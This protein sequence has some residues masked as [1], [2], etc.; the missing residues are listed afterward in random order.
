MQQLYFNTPLLQKFHL[1]I[2]QQYRK[3]KIARLLNSA[4][5]ILISKILHDS[6]INNIITNANYQ[7][8]SLDGVNPILVITNNVLDA[9]RLYLEL[10]TFINED[11]IAIFPNNEKL[12]YENITPQHYITANR[13]RVLWQISTKQ[14]AVVI[15]DAASLQERL[16]PVSYLYERMLILQTT[17][18]LNIMEL[19]RQLI[20]GN[21]SYVEQILES[22][23]FTIRGS[24]IDIIPMGHHELIRIELFDDEIESLKI[25]DQVTKKTIEVIDKIELI[26]VKEYPLDGLDFFKTKFNDYFAKDDTYNNYLNSVKNLSWQHLKAGTESYL[27]LFFENTYTIFDYLTNNWQIIYHDNLL[28]LLNNNWQ[29]ISRR[30]ALCKQQYPCLKPNDLFI[31][32]DNIF[33]KINAFNAYNIASNGD[34]NSNIQ[35]LPDI[36]IDQKAKQPLYRLHEFS[37]KYQNNWIILFVDNIGRVE[38]IKQML[39]KEGVAVNHIIDYTQIL[40]TAKLGVINLVCANLHNGF[41]LHDYIFITET[42]LNKNMPLINNNLNSIN[43]LASVRQRRK[44][45]LRKE[46]NVTKNFDHNAVLNNVADIKIGDLIVH[47]NHGIA[48][49]MGLEIQNICDV[50]Y[51][52][53]VLQYQNDAKIFV[54]INNL[55]LISKYSAIDNINNE[56]LVHHLGTNNWRKIIDKTKKNIDDIAAH[57][58]ELYAARNINSGIKFNLIEEYKTFAS[59]FG[60]EPTIDQVNCFN[61]VLTDM[62]SDKPMERLICGDVGFGKTEVAIRAAFVCAMNGYQVVVLC[63]T[64]LLV[65]Q[66]YQ[67]FINRFAKFPITIAEISRFKTKKEIQDSLILIKNGQIDIIIGTHRLIQNDVQFAKL[68]LILIDEEHRFGVAQK[69]KLKKLCSNVDT[70]SMTATPVPRSLSMALDGIRDL[71]II[72]TPPQKRLPIN[73]IICIEDFEIIK[74][75]ILRELRR[76]GQV[77]FLYNDVATIGS[78]YHKLNNLNLNINIAVAHGQMQEHELEMTVRDFIWQKYQLLL[79]STIIETG[80][81]IANANTIIIYRAD[82]LGLAQL[83]QL[84]GRVGR[85]HHQAYCY[86]IIPDKINDNA[87]KRLEAI[88]I[89][90]ALGSGFNLAMHDLE[91]RG[92]GEILGKKQ[93]GNIEGVGLPLYAQMLQ[94]AIKQ[95]KTQNNKLLKENA[96]HNTNMNMMDHN[97][98]DNKNYHTDTASCE[99]DLDI[100]MIIPSDYCTQIDLRLMYYKQLQQ[101]TN[102]ETID[103]IYQ[104]LIN[105]FGM[106]PVVTQNLINS[107][108]L[109]IKACSIGISKLNINHKNIK[110]IFHNPDNIDVNHIITVMQKL[111]TCR[112][113]KNNEL[114]YD[115]ISENDQARFTNANTILDDLIN[116]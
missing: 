81:D 69:E 3:H 46:R 79:C 62:Q 116:Q 113:T 77:F 90:T 96:N 57:L 43:Y 85:S 52:V 104:E 53:L 82:K 106:P 78:M 34:L 67:N 98:T 28:E 10:T 40:E 39:L 73:T 32:T 38:I 19:Q 33:I 59:D 87:Q 84:R 89:N 74:E 55:H 86:L 54:P 60:F 93:S 70:L 35:H 37:K 45:E 66:H 111:K 97:S 110:I 95:I 11:Y 22:G 1:D 13:L 114:I 102:N 112:L 91:I 88:E 107:Y 103:G 27:P 2:N 115:K 18:K 80:I 8:N 30:Y 108:Y 21:Y 83:H 16:P 5:I 23:E 99:I 65:E 105:L 51:D 4:D 61:D 42:E 24:I 76:G 9:N 12:P 101:A 17:Q 44:L 41:I 100:T 47:I 50:E 6:N 92:A 72:A 58:L 20:V 63:P 48:R 14:L 31:T 75:A 26:P 29:D 71:S 94:Q 25:I 49:Y 109:K 68:G 7:V 36:S 15:I 56:H 64:T